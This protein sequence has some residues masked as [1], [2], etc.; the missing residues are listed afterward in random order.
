MPILLF[1]PFANFG[2]Q[3]IQRPPHLGGTAGRA[4]HM[5]PNNGQPYRVTRMVTPGQGGKATFQITVPTRPTSMRVTKAAISEVSDRNR[6]DATPIS[7]RPSRRPFSQNV[8]FESYNHPQDRVVLRRST[9]EDAGSPQEVWHQQS[10]L[11]SIEGQNYASEHLL[12]RQSVKKSPLKKISPIPREE[13][14]PTYRTRGNPTTNEK[15]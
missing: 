11:I 2:N 14:A 9:H 3:S 1:S 5:S 12:P 10:P 4:G 8:R 13:E 15:G 7:D 6:S